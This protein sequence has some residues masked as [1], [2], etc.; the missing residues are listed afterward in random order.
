MLFIFAIFLNKQDER[1]LIRKAELRKGKTRQAVY[2]L[3]N[4]EA[5]WYYHC[6][7]G[8]AISMTYSEFVSVTLVIQHAKCVRHIALCGLSGS[9][10]SH[11]LIINSTIFGVGG[12]C[13]FCLLHYSDLF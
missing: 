13:K 9:T 8:K 11:H 3:R 5:R 4:S 12:G 10:S 1:H 2:V 7:S 6:F